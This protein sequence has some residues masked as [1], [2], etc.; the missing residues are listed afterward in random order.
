MA[1]YEAKW[2][3]NEYLREYSIMLNEYMAYIT[4]KFI[5][6]ISMIKGINYGVII[7]TKTIE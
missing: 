5:I 3:I 1:F 4:L 6:A 7:Q 2:S